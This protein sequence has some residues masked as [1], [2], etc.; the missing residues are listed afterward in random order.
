MRQRTG[1]LGCF[2]VLCVFFQLA[3]SAIGIAALLWLNPTWLDRI[4]FW[5]GRRIPPDVVGASGAAGSVAVGSV[6]GAAPCPAWPSLWG[7]RTA[8]SGPPP[9]PS[10]SCAVGGGTVLE[11]IYPLPE[12]YVEGEDMS[13]MTATMAHAHEAHRCKYAPPKAPDPVPENTHQ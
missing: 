6:A 11:L 2:G 4:A 12:E 5:R 7:S 8:K 1:S 3:V 10:W 9:C 13:A